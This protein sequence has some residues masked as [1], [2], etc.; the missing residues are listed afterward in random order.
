M[1]SRETTVDGVVLQVL[2]RKGMEDQADRILAETKSKFAQYHSLFG[3]YP[4]RRLAVVDTPVTT[5]L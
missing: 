3:P 5:S 1:T 4:Y 2:V